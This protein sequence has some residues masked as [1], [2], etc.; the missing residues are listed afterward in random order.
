MSETLTHLR[1][2][3]SNFMTMEGMEYLPLLNALHE[4]MAADEKA[5]I[6]LDPITNRPL[7][8]RDEEGGVLI[9]AFLSVTGA[10]S[11]PAEREGKRPGVA[12]VRFGDLPQF[13]NGQAGVDGIVFEPET[14]GFVAVPALLED[15]A[16][17]EVTSHIILVTG[18]IFEAAA[19]VMVCPTDAKLSGK[20]EVEEA[21]LAFTHGADMEEELPGELQLGDVL[22][23]ALSELPGVELDFE[24]ILYSVSP[25]AANASRLGVCYATVL[26]CA[27]QLRARSVV[28]PCI[29]TGR[30]GID[31]ALA[32]AASTEAVLNWMESRPDYVMDVYFCCHDDE[33]R[34]LYQ[35]YFDSIA[36]E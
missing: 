13:L 21:L 11:F 36:G 29:G 16:E 30:N 34:Q 8:V 28:F 9:P 6:L 20:G 24:Q 3:M 22:G 33:R 19:S 12:L 14:I 25:D 23:T 26:E 15:A 7:R 35:D 4:C 17:A 32:V 10:N 27:R 31:P 18:D 5:F 1:R 2:T